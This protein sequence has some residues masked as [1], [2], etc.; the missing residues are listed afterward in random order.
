[1]TGIIHLQA[2]HQGQVNHPRVQTPGIVPGNRGHM[3]VPQAGQ[4][5]LDDA[6]KAQMLGY[7]A[8]DLEVHRVSG[9]GLVLEGFARLVR[10]QE[11]GLG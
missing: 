1:M 11:P 5:L 2:A 9:V 4:D 10:K 6:V 7:Q 8:F 3:Q